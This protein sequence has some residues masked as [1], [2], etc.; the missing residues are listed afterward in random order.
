MCLK[1][2]VNIKKALMSKY[3]FIIDFSFLLRELIKFRCCKKHTNKVGSKEGTVFVNIT[4][5]SDQFLCKD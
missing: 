3:K 5:F 4:A 1:V 2:C